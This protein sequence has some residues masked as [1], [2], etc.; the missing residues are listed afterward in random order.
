M[1]ILPLL[2]R[3]CYCIR[4]RCFIIYLTVSYHVFLS[5]LHVTDITDMYVTSQDG[6]SKTLR[7]FK[8]S[9]LVLT[10]ILKVP[11]LSANSTWL[12]MLDLPHY[13]PKCQYFFCVVREDYTPCICPL[14]CSS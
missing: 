4:P 2:L 14:I 3:M 8:P 5:L 12:E 1:V 13:T 7:I 9:C 6:E 11:H 10:T